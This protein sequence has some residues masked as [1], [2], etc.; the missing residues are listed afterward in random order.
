MISSDHRNHW[1]T[2][3]PATTTRPVSWLFF[4]FQ[5]VFDMVWLTQ[6]RFRLV[7]FVGVSRSVRFQLL[8][9]IRFGSVHNFRSIR[10]GL[11][12]K[13]YIYS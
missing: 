11:L 5:F 12:A 2:R 9:I 1:P 3:W 8:H 7:R 13:E 4:V 10:F 6:F